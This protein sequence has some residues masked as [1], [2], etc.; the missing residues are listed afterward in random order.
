MKELI[1]WI[2]GIP[3]FILCAFCAGGYAA[4]A[5]TILLLVLL[6]LG[7]SR[8]FKYLLLYVNHH[9]LSTGQS[10]IGLKINTEMQGIKEELKGIIILAILLSLL[11]SIFF[12]DPFE[13]VLPKPAAK[14]VEYLLFMIVGL[15]ALGFSD[16][17][18]S[19]SGGGG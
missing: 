1:K 12:F 2:F 6:V 3:F 8:I 10:P 7:V 4:W 15:I 13:I 16:S 18:E 11:L 9:N 14:L 17:H 19:E 5:C